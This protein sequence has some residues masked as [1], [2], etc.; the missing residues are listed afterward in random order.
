MSTVVYKIIPE[1][2][3]NT[4]GFSKNYRIFSATEPLLGAINITNFRDQLNLGSG[5]EQYVI[6]KFRYSGDGANWSLWFTFSLDNLTEIESL[7]FGNANVFFEVKYEYDDGTYNPL[8]Q[9]VTVNAIKFNV[10]S[11]VVTE[12]LYT[13]TVFC[14]SEKCPAII[15]TQNATFKPYEVSTAI[16]IAK[17][18]S[19]QTNRIFGLDTIYFKTEPDREGGDFIFK[20]WTIYKTVARKCA[21]VLVPD[22]KFPDNKPN[23]AEFGVDFEVPFEIHIDHHYF[24]TIF[25]PDSQPRKR[26]YLYFPLSNRMYEIQGSYLFR[27]FMMEPIYWKIQLTKFHPNVDMA[28]KTTDRKFLDNIVL[29]SED[30][31]GNQA[32]VQTQDALMQQQFSTISTKFDEVREK[33][34]P[35]INFNSL[36]LTYNYSPLIEYY[37]DMRDVV[38]TSVSYQVTQTGSNA[39]QLLTPSQPYEIY[40]YEGSQIYGNWVSRKLNSGDS[41]VN[42]NGGSTPIRIIGPKDSH[43]SQG[44]FI[45]IQGFT[46]LALTQSQKVSL[47]PSSPGVFRF[48]QSQ[49]AIIYKKSASTDIT[50]NLTYCSLINFNPGSQNLVILNGYDN[51]FGK[52][53]TITCSIQD[54]SGSPTLTIIV[55][56]NGIQNLFKIG[57]INYS[58]WYALIIP[59]SSEFGQLEVNV[60]SFSQDPSNQNNLNGVVQVFTGAVKTGAFSFVTGEPWSVPGGNYSIANIRIF[61]TMIQEEDHE[62]VISQLFVRDESMLEIIDNARPRLNS[63]FIAINR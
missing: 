52:G 5:Q 19:Y 58:T 23:F 8:D 4:I 33:L 25:G 55:S 32:K 44:K 61:N 31:F 18:M 41:L 34:H 20:E 56:I 40:A 7:N 51:L 47:Q 9:P 39:D 2:N 30:L 28:I 62:F 50:P 1:I 12:D 10:V 15:A 26:D 17:E 3:K 16:G 60:Y 35:D 21:K 42:P 29:T 37:Y 14:S 43:T 38:G 27:G 48:N 57:E 53:L 63:P 46:T 49:H 36:N 13:P 54:N 59:A 24:Q 22:N 6:R 11:S 45:S